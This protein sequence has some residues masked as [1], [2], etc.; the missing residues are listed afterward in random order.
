MN[1]TLGGIL[2]AVLLDIICK[3]GPLYGSEITRE[4]ERVSGGKIVLKA[5]SLYPALHSFVRD[6]L[7][8]VETC[9]APNSG[10][11]VNYYEITEK[12][13]RELV[14]LREEVEALIKFGE[15]ALGL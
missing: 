10:G 2:R 13:Q 9:P 8:C 4:V 14:A 12:G 5:G 1:R 15:A 7:V 11:R 6:E 3:K